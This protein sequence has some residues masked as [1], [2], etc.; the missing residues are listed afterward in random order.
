VAWAGLVSRLGCGI[1]TVIIALRL[2]HVSPGRFLLA[3]SGRW[4]SLAVGFLGVCLTLE[5]LPF[6][7][8]WAWFALKVFLAQLFYWPLLWIILL[9]RETK[10]RCRHWGIRAWAG[11]RL[12]GRIRRSPPKEAALP[13]PSE[14]D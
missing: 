6:E 5:Q 7:Q 14:A 10:D 11:M 2:M 8:A 4:L 1:I 12:T 3:T 9:D 13:A